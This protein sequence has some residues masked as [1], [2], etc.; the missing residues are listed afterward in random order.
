MR[1]RYVLLKNSEG[2]TANTNWTSCG[3]PP[4]CNAK[5]VSVKAGGDTRRNGDG[6]GGR[7]GEGTGNPTKLGP[8]WGSVVLNPTVKDRNFLCV[9]IDRPR[10]IDL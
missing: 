7:G 5:V 8:V 1:C 2:Q 4:R 10:Q 9:N 3:F 6:G